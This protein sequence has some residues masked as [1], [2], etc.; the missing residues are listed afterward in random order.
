[1]NE[2]LIE[3]ATKALEIIKKKKVDIR[4]LCTC[5]EKHNLNTYNVF[6]ASL[7]GKK[8]LTQKEYDLLKDVLL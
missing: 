5:F 4:V 1:M 8:Q 3:E 6:A 2:E 7:K